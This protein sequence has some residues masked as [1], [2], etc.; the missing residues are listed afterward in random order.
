M[1]IHGLAGRS[2]DDKGEDRKIQ[3]SSQD[4]PRA[5]CGPTPTSSTEK[6]NES[7]AGA[8]AGSSDGAIGTFASSRST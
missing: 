8:G 5:E 2:E 3:K 1:R 7:T 4:I 6:R